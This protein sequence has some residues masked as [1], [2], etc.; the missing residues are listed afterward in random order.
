MHQDT[1]SARLI[2]VCKRTFTQQP[3][4]INE[5]LQ[6]KTSVICY[7][8]IVDNIVT[9]V[10]HSNDSIVYI[11]LFFPPRTTRLKW[12]NAILGYR[13]HSL[14]Y[15]RHC[16]MIL[17]PWQRAWYVV[18]VLSQQSKW[19]L[20]DLLGLRY[21]VQGLFWLPACLSETGDWSTSPKPTMSMSFKNTLTNM[22]VLEKVT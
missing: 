19:T 18:S 14:L 6:L 9:E 21:G 1:K 12:L 11:H 7:T 4:P 13:D 20:T 10:Q 15:Q 3:V 5:R 2:V 22:S 17:L 8:N 16:D